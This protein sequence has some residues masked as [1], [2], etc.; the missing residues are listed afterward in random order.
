[1]LSSSN[2]L[3]GR[4]WRYANV[5][6]FSRNSTPY[7]LIKVA[8]LVFNFVI[9]YFISLNSY[10]SWLNW[11]P[12]K[13]TWVFLQFYFIW[14]TAHNDR[15]NAIPFISNLSS[16]ALTTNRIMILLFGIL[17]YWY[18]IFILSSWNYKSSLGS[19]KPGVSIMVTCIPS[20]NIFP[21]HILQFL[22]M[23][24]LFYPA[25]NSLDYVI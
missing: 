23:L 4:S 20:P 16:R 7:S 2:P 25:K 19:S 9:N 5:E 17:A 15:W 11:V 8:T 14:S 22:V 1:M 18:K 12:I 10:R 13:Y 21:V 3:K 24:K 6:L